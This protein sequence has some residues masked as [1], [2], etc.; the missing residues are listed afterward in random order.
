MARQRPKSRTLH[1]D[2]IQLHRGFTI[3]LPLFN[4]QPFLAL[5]VSRSPMLGFYEIKLVTDAGYAP[6]LWRTLRSSKVRWKYEYSTWRERERERE[7][8]ETPDMSIVTIT[9]PGL[10][11]S[12][13]Y[14]PFFPIPSQWVC[15]CY[16]YGKSLDNYAFTY[17]NQSDLV[18]LHIYRCVC[19]DRDFVSF[20]FLWE[21]SCQRLS[22]RFVCVYLIPPLLVRPSRGFVYHSISSYY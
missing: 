14:T 21:V 19:L 11:H 5:L 7:T 17:I 18:R 1:K 13:D 2:R 9:N 12:R 22:T 16:V 3:S 4:L 20:W 6:I 8:C 10:L 15:F